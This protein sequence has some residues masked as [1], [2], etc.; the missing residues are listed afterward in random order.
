MPCIRRGTADHHR[1]REHG[2]GYATGASDRRRCMPTPR[3][4]DRAGAPRHSRRRM[5]TR[6][7][8]CESST[9]EG[10]PGR[11]R[12][13]PR[14]RRPMNS[15]LFGFSADEQQDR[16]TAGR[17]RP[18]AAI[19]VDPR[20]PPRHLRDRSPGARTRAPLP[21]RANVRSG[22]RP[23]ISLIHD[24]DGRRLPAARQ[25]SSRTPPRSARSAPATMPTTSSRAGTPGCRS[26]AATASG[27]ALNDASAIGRA[28]PIDGHER[29]DRLTIV[30][31]VA[32]RVR[33]PSPAAIAG[34]RQAPVP[35]NSSA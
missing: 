8:R 35:R 10:P 13:S 6:S 4:R 1:A 14:P 20:H 2:S 21:S 32:G 23:R 24:D 33:R 19:V 26:S 7:A 28:I 27:S 9:V 11:P 16:E 17:T 15:R 5:D 31:P 3:H 18:E 29:R 22:A 34:E 12:R 25:R 30:R